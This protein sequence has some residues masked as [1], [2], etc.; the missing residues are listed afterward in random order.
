[1]NSKEKDEYVN[2]TMERMT[3]MEPYYC[4]PFDNPKELKERASDLLKQLNSLGD[5]AQEEKES[6]MRQLFGT[7]NK[8][9]SGCVY[10]SRCMSGVFRTCDSSIAEKPHV[11]KCA[12]NAWRKCLARC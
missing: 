4:N 3:S 7:Y 9:R 6:I 5:N 8:H 10:C 11:D 12:D 1:M 2:Q